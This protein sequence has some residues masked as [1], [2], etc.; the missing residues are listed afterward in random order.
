MKVVIA[1]DSFKGSA[2]SLRVA[3]DIQKAWR[4]IRPRDEV[5]LISLADG[6]EGTI[7]VFAPLFGSRLISTR[8]SGATLGR[9]YEGFCIVTNGEMAAV[10]LASAAGLTLVPAHQRDPKRTTTFGFGELIARAASVP[11]VKRLVL[12]LG[13]S[14]TNDGGAGALQALGVRLTNTAG[15]K[16]ARGG[17]ALAD[18]RSADF[19][20]ANRFPD[21]EV[22]IACDVDNPLLGR[23]G[24]TY[25]FAPQKGATDDDLPLLESA[26]TRYADVLTEATGRDVR[27]VPGAGAAGG[28]A[29]GLLWLFPQA[30]LRPGIEIV[31]DAVGFD[32]AVR[33][34]DIVITGEGRLDAQTLSGKA[35]AGVIRRTRAVNP[36]AK[37]IAIVGSVSPPDAQ[38]ELARALGLSAVYPMVREGVTVEEAIRHPATH[39][40]MI[41]ERAANDFAS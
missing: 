17:A 31:L 33:D 27:N 18:L 36:R 13:G 14:A 15:R 38:G 29:A 34:A 10:E 8:Y 7:S 21:L 1:P 32:D 12:A 3:S 30:T 23:R 35:V 25:V 40:Q 6:G 5:T 16:L 20:K 41:A 37:I 4:R 11:G 9:M 19:S 24:A 22:V 26:M 39:L 2:T 28:T